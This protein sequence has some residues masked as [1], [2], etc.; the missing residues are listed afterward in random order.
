[1]SDY[2]ILPFYFPTTVIFV[3]D[4]TDFLVNLS[5]QLSPELAFQL[6]DS[7]ESALLALRGANNMTT[8][9]E[10]FFS[11][12]HAG[13]D[14]PLSHHVIEIN[15]DKIHREVYNEFR[16]EQVSVVVVDYDM[17]NINGI[18]FCRSI[19]DTAIKKVLLTGKA[20]EKIAVMAFNEGIIDRFIL[21]QDKAV[22]NVLNKTI[23]ELQRDYFNGIER[24]LAD[25]LAV[26]SHSFLQDALFAA[27]FQ[28]ICSEL[29]IVE[30]YLS[31]NPDGILML[32]S[33]G[34]ESLLLVI[35]DST[36]IS[37]YEIAYDQGAP[38]ELLTALK[39]NQLVPYFWKTQGNYTPSCHNWRDF[40]YPATEF[41]GKQWYYYSIVKNPPGYKTDTVLSY[42]E[43]IDH[44]DQ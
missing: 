6:Y 33:A 7:S 11:C 18:D 12:F 23:R 15:L 38:D 27:E 34:V 21:K 16:F 41:K 22:I 19:P 25:A 39:S 40:L 35:D 29:R 30:F 26:G 1:M 14:I 42:N 13:E 31:S 36:L 43:F 9:L 8:P 37:H 3:D 10:R 32:N 44:L 4:S 2:Q 20:D 28:K 24:M 5:L 17:P